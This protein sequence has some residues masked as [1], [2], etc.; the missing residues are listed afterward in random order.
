[1]NK[2]KKFK[3]SGILMAESENEKS[4]TWD[5]TSINI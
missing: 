2:G 3:Y 1:M 5:F 4:I